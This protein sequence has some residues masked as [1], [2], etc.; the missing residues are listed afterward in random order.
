MTALEIGAV[1][2]GN[3][4]IEIR[5]IVYKRQPVAKAKNVPK[6]TLSSR[7]LLI[8][9]EVMTMKEIEKRYDKEWVLIENPVCA[10]NL[11]VKGG[12]VLFHSTDKSELYEFAKRNK[13]HFWSF[14]VLFI[15]A[16][17]DDMIYVF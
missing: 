8:P 4:M 1:I 5:E 14:A 10:K 11:N 15:G 2:G 13:P 6:K 12:K 7:K 17:P 9:G 16:D 3:A